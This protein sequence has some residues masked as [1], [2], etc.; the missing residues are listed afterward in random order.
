MC[1]FVLLFVCVVCLWVCTSI[2]RSDF[3][4]LKSPAHGAVGCAHLTGAA[5]S[6]DSPSMRSKRPVAAGDADSASIV[7]PT[8]DVAA[9]SKY[10]PRDIQVGVCEVSV[11]VFESVS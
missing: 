4:P 3:R 5:A 11:H 7:F 8:L 6:F 2:H 10:H 9:V 1:R